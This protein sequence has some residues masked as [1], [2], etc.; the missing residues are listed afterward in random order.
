M[1]STLTVGLTLVALSLGASPAQ[2][3]PAFPGAE[4]VAASITGGRGGRVV[5]VTTLDATG[6]GSLQEALSLDEPRIIVFDVSGVIVADELVIESGNVT[7]AGESA[8]GAGITIDGRLSAAYTDAVGNIIIRHVRVRPT[9]PQ[10]DG[11]QID[12]L[13]F[14]LSSQVLLDHVSASFGVDETIDLYGA[15]DITVQW[16]TI[17]SSA[18]EGHP[19]GQHNYGL[20]QGPDGARA[21]IHHNLFAHQRNR[22][23]ALATGPSEVVNNVAYNVRHGFVHHNPASNRFDIIGNAYLAGGDDTLFPF[24]FDD[25]AGSELSYYLADN[26]IDDPG[27]FTGVVD[28]PWSEPFDHHTFENLG[29]PIEYRADS[30]FDWEAAVPERVPVTTQSSSDAIDMVLDCAGA[31]PRDV[32]TLRSVQETRDRTGSWGA[33]VP[34]DLMEGLTPGTP[35]PDADG[36]GMP[37]TWEQEHG[38]DDADPN[39]AGTITAEGYMAIEVY[40]HERA[41]TLTQGACPGADVEPPGGGTGGDDTSTGTGGTPPGSETTDGPSNTSSGADDPT[42]QGSSGGATDSASPPSDDDPSGC[43]CTEGRGSGGWAW[44]SLLGAI[45]AVRRRR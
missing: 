43:G 39:D 18:T 14:G 20:L 33:R 2:A 23:P 7:I 37:D 13:Q 44:L 8:P 30:P 25:A 9:N 35:E 24:F 6:P 45:L 32:V 1:R 27:Q 26:Y 40:L 28:N 15:S 41:A 22:N 19:E 38:Y 17:E 42:T 12:A 36:D 29:R 21:S 10:G 16:S 4:G 3:L 11:N 5:K 31:W 34:S